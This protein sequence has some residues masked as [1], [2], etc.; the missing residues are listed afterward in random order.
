MKTK[1]YRA[2][3]ESLISEQQAI[4]QANPP[5][6]DAWKIA[7][8]EIHRLASLLTGKKAYRVEWGGTYQA[9]VGSET[10]TSL[11]S[12]RGML[13]HDTDMKSDDIDEL[14]EEGFSGGD[15]AWIRL[16]EVQP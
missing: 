4:Q 3:I 15:C 6:S 16:T 1:D 9:A 5:T 8:E 12:V 11:E 14:I 2:S 13:E 10:F 7:S